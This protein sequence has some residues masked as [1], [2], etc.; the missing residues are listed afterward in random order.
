MGWEKANLEGVRGHEFA[1]PSI[2][3]FL[4]VQKSGH[5]PPKTNFDFWPLRKEEN[6]SMANQLRHIFCSRGARG[7]CS[8]RSE[9]QKRIK[10]YHKRQVIRYMNV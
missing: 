3:S 7:F 1:P 8:E 2:S 9:D 4:K 10:K 5:E 6:R